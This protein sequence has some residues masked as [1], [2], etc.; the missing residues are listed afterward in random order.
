MGQLGCAVIMLSDLL[1]LGSKILW[2]GDLTMPEKQLPFEL[3]L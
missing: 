2:F 1:S 3:H